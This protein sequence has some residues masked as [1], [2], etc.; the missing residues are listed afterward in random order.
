MTPLR[1]QPL[2]LLRIPPLAVTRV[3]PH[4]P[5]PGAVQA[6]AGPAG[7]AGLAGWT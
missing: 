3:Q 4:C 5:P 6:R 2:T 7:P 1:V